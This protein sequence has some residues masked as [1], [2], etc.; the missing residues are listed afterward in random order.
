MIFMSELPE[1]LNYQEMPSIKNITL[2][3]KIELPD[4]TNSGKMF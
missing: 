1:C 3:K 2:L 4:N